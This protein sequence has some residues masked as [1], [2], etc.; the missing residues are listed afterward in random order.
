MD[1]QLSSITIPNSVASI[2]EGAFKG[3][4]MKSITIGA[5]KDYHV[6]AFPHNFWDFYQSQGRRAGAYTWS[7]RIWS[8]K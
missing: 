8:V 5:D 2:G 1:N 4:Q 7:G 6:L 3:N